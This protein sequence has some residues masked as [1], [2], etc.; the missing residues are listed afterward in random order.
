[1][2]MKFGLDSWA[3]L[4]LRAV[5]ESHRISDSREHHTYVSPTKTATCPLCPRNH[6]IFTKYWWNW[7]SFLICYG[8]QHCSFSSLGSPTGQVCRYVSRCQTPLVR[9]AS[10]W[11][12]PPSQIRE[13]AVGNG[14]QNDLRKLDTA[15]DAKFGAF[16]KHGNIVYN[17]NTKVW[18]KNSAQSIQT[19]EEY[20]RRVS[21]A[22]P[23]TRKV[24]TVRHM[25]AL[26]QATY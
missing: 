24:H 1:M 11:L 21:S 18:E 12:N 13:G 20:R 17:T 2:W 15:M 19:S 26:S 4:W 5:S 9:Y 8:I 7:L 10:C 23:R 3:K 16:R 25:L 14:E 6:V 22:T